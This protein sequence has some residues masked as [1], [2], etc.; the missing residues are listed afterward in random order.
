MLPKKN[1]VL[2]SRLPRQRSMD[3]KHWIIACASIIVVLSLFVA[4]WTWKRMATMMHQ[5]PPARSESLDE[6]IVWLR[7]KSAMI[8]SAE[9]DPA[10]SNSNNRTSTHRCKATRWTKTIDFDDGE[11]YD[12]LANIVNQFATH[13][14]QLLLYGGSLLGA[15]RHFGIM[16]WDGDVDFM[17][18]ST[19]TTKINHVL[20]HVLK[21]EW[22]YNNDGDGPGT[23]GFGYHVVTPYRDID[24]WLYSFVN[25]THSSCV[26]VKN[27]CQRWYRRFW[28]AP[29]PA[30]KTDNLLPCYTIPFGPWMFPSPRNV[31]VVLDR[32]YTPSWTKNCKGW[33]KGVVACESMFEEYAF[34]HTDGNVYTLK[35]GR[36]VIASFRVMNGVF[37]PI[38]IDQQ[39]GS[40]AQSSP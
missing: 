30:Y 10:K 28:N 12:L 35:K 17:V 11:E 27:G 29:P 6:N 33:Q 13:G 2:V 23:T 38:T 36:T 40:F 16:P 9:L 25:T 24:F 21:L 15:R 1:M 39:H 14:I 34:V 37:Q 4:S 32:T 31:E 3:A 18:F 7:R 26:G 22:R 8:R 5:P 20:D 19:N